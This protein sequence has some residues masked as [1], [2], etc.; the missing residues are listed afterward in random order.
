MHNA[1]VKVATVWS[2][3]R[4]QKHFSSTSSSFFFFL[5]P[6][7][8]FDGDQITED[9]TKTLQHICGDR[10]LRFCFMIFFKIDTF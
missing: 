5:P 10:E 4:Q 7:T 6:L 2:S 8:K 3:D 1:F 9:I